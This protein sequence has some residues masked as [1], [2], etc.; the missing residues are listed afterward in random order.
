MGLIISALLFMA[1][2]LAIGER[3]QMEVKLL[4][5]AVVF[6]ILSQVLRAFKARFSGDRAKRFYIDVR[7]WF[8]TVWSAVLL[9]SFLM[10]FFIQGFKIPSGSMRSTLLEGD[11]LF[12]NKFIYG[13]HVPMSGGVRLWQRHHVERG[14]IVVF[15]C[16]PIAMTKEERDKNIVK[17]FIKRCVAVG[18]DTV[19][20]KNKKL[21][22]NGQLQDEPYTQYVD[23]MV[24]P[25]VSIFPDNETYQ[26]AWE[27]GKF[28]PMPSY[29]IRDNFGPVTVPPGMYFMMGDNRDRSFDSRF[30]GP[31]PDRNVKGRPLVLYWP[32]SRLHMIK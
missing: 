15:I 9:A 25:P 11:H 26:R 14:E 12:V 5:E 13:F 2:F 23:D 20:V 8:E 32:L 6:F 21:Y 30:W 28:E 24:Y 29:V 19:E 27:A 7:E 4:T 18:G 3:M 17:E 10:F 31:L 1:M 16:P 22:V